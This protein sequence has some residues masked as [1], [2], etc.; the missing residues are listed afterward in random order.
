MVIRSSFRKP[1]S[2]AFRDSFRGRS[3]SSDVVYW[4]VNGDNLLFN[5]CQVVNQEV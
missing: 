5:G 2:S 4:L 3:Q 1:F